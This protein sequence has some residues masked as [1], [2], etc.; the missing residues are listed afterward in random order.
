MDIAGQRPW[1]TLFLLLAARRD[2]KFYEW[3]RTSHVSQTV[4]GTRLALLS[5]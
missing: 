2:L 5:Q 4:T 3:T 1:L